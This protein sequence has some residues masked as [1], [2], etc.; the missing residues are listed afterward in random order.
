MKI[1][2]IL[3]VF[4]ACITLSLS[5]NTAYSS[6]VAVPF[7][8]T[9]SEVV[10]TLLGWLGARINATDM[11]DWNTKMDTVDEDVETFINQKYINNANYAS[12]LI[13]EF[14]NLITNSQITGKIENVSTNLFGALKDFVN[15]LITANTPAEPMP[16]TVGQKSFAQI[17]NLNG[18]PY[19]N[20]YAEFYESRIYGGLN[21]ASVYRLNISE[22]GVFYNKI[23]VI[24]NLGSYDGRVFS[25]VLD[26]NMLKSYIVNPPSYV[27]ETSTIYLR[28]DIQMFYFKD[29]VLKKYISYIDTVGGGDYLSS[30]SNTSRVYSSFQDMILSNKFTDPISVESDFTFIPGVNKVHDK[31][32][33]LD[34]LGVGT[35]TGA[36]SGDVIGTNTWE[37]VIGGTIALEDVIPFPL[38]DTVENVLIDDAY[39]DDDVDDTPYQG[40]Q[41]GP[42]AEYTMGS[43]VTSVFPF[44]IPFDL[45]RLVKVMSATSQAPRWEI[46]LNIRMIN[47]SYTFVLDMAPFE[48]LAS[49]FRLTETILFILAL[50]I[51]TRKLIG[52]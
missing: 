23:V 44:C 35:A 20:D 1:K 3:L 42:I 14:K 37:K 52:D 13:S 16:V 51:A 22:G 10:G 41:Y 8:W 48:S 18:I 46:P 7:T 32:G 36:I 49:I 28:G 5:V 38:V 45:V 4:L 50:I 15:D 31:Y 29:G 47:Y 30:L 40:I 43:I 24:G 17:A 11:S 39:V 19:E 2:R 6:A 33:N 27:L 9:V 26:G 25:Y 21:V 12:Q 34:N